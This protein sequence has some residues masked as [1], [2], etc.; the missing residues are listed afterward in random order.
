LAQLLIEPV[1]S[2]SG[3]QH[4]NARA[5]NTIANMARMVTASLVA[6]LR[7]ASSVREGASNDGAM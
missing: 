4:A 5:E 7:D 3:V 1:T 2:L 6:G